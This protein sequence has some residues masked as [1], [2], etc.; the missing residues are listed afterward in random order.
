MFKNLKKLMIIGH[1]GA[2]IKLTDLSNNSLVVNFSV[3]V[4]DY[5]ADRDNPGKFI[6]STEWFKVAVWGKRKQNGKTLAEHCKDN[7]KKGSCVYVEGNLN[8][9]IF[10]SKDGIWKCALKVTAKTVVFLDSKKNEERN[11][12][13]KPPITSPW[14][15]EKTTPNDPFDDDLPF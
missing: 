2:D 14:A 7:L 8:S 5:R 13:E 6:E 3:A 1:V 10:E 15:P 12:G 4:N 11:V 9:E